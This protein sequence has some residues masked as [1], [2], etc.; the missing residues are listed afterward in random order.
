MGHREKMINGDE[1]DA[2][3]RHARQLYKPPAGVVSGVKK[4]F[5]RRVRRLAKRA[6]LDE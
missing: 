1:I 3:C 2:L 4:R 5:N 6:L